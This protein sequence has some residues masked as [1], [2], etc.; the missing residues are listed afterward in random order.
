MSE[1]G[2]VWLAHQSGGLGVGGSNPLAP[3]NIKQS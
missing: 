2:A 1:R 3:T